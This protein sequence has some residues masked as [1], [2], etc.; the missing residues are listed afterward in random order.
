MW[1]ILLFL[2]ALAVLAYGLEWVIDQPGSLTLDWGEFHVD[3][4]IPVAVGGLVLTVAALMLLWAL[5]ILGVRAAVAASRPFGRTA[6][7]KRFQGFVARH[8]R[9][10]S[11]RFKG[12]SARGRRKPRN[13]CRANPWPNISRL[14]RRNSRA[15]AARPRPPSTK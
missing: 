2:V 3:T 11:R 4:S 1:F 6:A 9:G 13:T 15:I 5:L 10:R 14:R 8:D 12:R 7:R